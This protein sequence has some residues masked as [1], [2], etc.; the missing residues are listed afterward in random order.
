MA[1]NNMALAAETLCRHGVHNGASLL[2]CLTCKTYR[3]HLYGHHKNRQWQRHFW[4]SVTR[5]DQALQA[6]IQARGGLGQARAVAG[7][8]RAVR[9][10]EFQVVLGRDEQRPAQLLLE[11]RGRGARALVHGH[12]LRHHALRR[13]LAQLLLLAGASILACF[14]RT[15]VHCDVHCMLSTHPEGHAAKPVLTLPDVRARRT[16]S[17]AAATVCSACSGH[18]WN[19]LM[20]V[21]LAR[22]GKSRQRVRSFSPTGDM[23][24]TMCRL[25]RQ[26]CLYAA[27]QASA[28][29]CAPRSAACKQAHALQAALNF[30][31]HLRPDWGASSTLTCR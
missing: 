8:L 29:T 14:V 7:Q 28:V 16:L 9:R 10:H 17:S 11:A 13:T 18:G 25:S 22:P 5:L 1:L 15:I 31:K 30:S 27:Q 4:K 19:Q 26:R 2:Q 21:L 24:S 6:A 12:H 3:R 23:A 20:T